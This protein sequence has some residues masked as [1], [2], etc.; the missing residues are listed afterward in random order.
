MLVN[1]SVH[2][3]DL[4]NDEPMKN[5]TIVLAFLIQVTTIHTSDK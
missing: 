4:P 3:C 5:N 2:A 1:A